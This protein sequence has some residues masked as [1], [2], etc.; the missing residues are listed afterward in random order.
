VSEHTDR[1]GLYVLVILILINTCFTPTKKEI[2][3]IVHEECR[4]AVSKKGETR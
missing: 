1:T 3:K 2:R 4:A